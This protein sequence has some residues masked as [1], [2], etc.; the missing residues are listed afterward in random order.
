MNFGKA[1]HELKDHKEVR[2]KVWKENCRLKWFDDVSDDAHIAFGTVNGILT[3]WN[4]SGEDL[5]A[6]DWEYYDATADREERLR[7]L[8]DEIQV[9][10]NRWQLEL[11]NLPR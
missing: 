1:L 5:T 8:A 9:T 7:S 2:R 4:P 11:K 3:S 6:E 10:V